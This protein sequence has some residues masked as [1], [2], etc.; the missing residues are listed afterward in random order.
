MIFISYLCVCVLYRKN[1][2]VSSKLAPVSVV[3]LWIQ[4]FMTNCCL[5]Q[6]TKHHNKVVILMHLFVGFL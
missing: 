3:K 1:N 2:A 5:K 4:V 6:C